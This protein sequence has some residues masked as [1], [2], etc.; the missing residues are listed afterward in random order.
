MRTLIFPSNLLYLFSL[1]SS[2]LKLCIGT[3]TR[4]S[5]SMHLIYVPS[6]SAHNCR[7]HLPVNS[8]ANLGSQTN[9]WMPPLPHSTSVFLV[10]VGVPWAW[11]LPL[12]PGP[13][14][15]PDSRGDHAL[16]SS[17]L[18]CTLQAYPE[19]KHVTNWSLL[20]YAC[21]GRRL[22][23]TALQAWWHYIVCTA[24]Q[25]PLLWTWLM[26]PQP[27]MSGGTLHVHC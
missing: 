3:L 24:R 13:H 4:L 10:Y 11:Q 23:L 26:C 7:G 21:H 16:P 17:V 14:G 18:S 22:L 6:C 19:G 20:V 1:S 5:L 2:L 15:Y 12:L 9:S 27:V 8:H 25:P